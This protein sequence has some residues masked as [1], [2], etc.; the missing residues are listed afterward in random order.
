MNLAIDIGNT[1]LKK[2]SFSN[3]KLDKIKHINYSKNDFN[4]LLIR[5]KKT[6]PKYDKI[7]ICSVVPELNKLIKREI[8]NKNIF[9]INK[10][11]L[12]A[13]IHKSVNIKQLGTDRLINV[14]GANNIFPKINHFIVIDLG[15]ATTLDLIIN[16]KYF[17]GVILPG[18]NTSYSNLF[19]LASGIKSIS[20]MKHNDIIGKDTKGAILS[21]YN[22]GYRLMIESY[23]KFLSNKYNYKFKV[24]FT[25]GYASN[26]INKQN[27]FYYRED[28]TLLGIAYYDYLV[29]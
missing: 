25:G 4:K 16:K 2:V 21:G 28:L 22:T 6:F 26:I 1:S 12:K 13:N 10:N 19:S 15:T 7:Y 17:G 8:S 18:L 5:L 27:N 9:F 3:L 23:I 29:K 14:I 24:I 20:L 11:I